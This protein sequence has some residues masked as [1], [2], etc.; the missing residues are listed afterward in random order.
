MKKTMS[1]RNIARMNKY[2]SKDMKLVDVSKH[3]K[4]DIKTLNLFA[5]GSK[6]STAETPKATPK[7]E[8]KPAA[9]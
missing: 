2:L 1:K 8:V 4:I 3:L 7:A 6:K 5:K 9:K